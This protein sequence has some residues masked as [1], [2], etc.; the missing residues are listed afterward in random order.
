[1]K[2]ARRPEYVNQ[3]DCSVC[4]RIGAAWGYFGNGEVTIEGETGR[5][6]PSDI[7]EPGLSF[8]FCP[9]CGSTTNW[10]ALAHAPRER[11]GVN[12]RLFKPGDLDGLE[13]RFSDGLGREGAGP[14]PPDRH[15]PITVRER[16]PT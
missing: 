16:W 13:A 14:R 6:Q 10:A 12:M 15:A 2:L 7:A 4:L 9:S 1:M 3:C 11:M 8:H 5:F